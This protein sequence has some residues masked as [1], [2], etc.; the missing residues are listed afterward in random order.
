MREAASPDGGASPWLRATLVAASPD[1]L[2]GAPRASVARP[3][4][5]LRYALEGSPGAVAL[6]RV[7][8]RVALSHDDQVVVEYRALEWEY[9][10]LGP[11]PERRDDLHDFDARR[12]GWSPPSIERLLRRSG[13]GA[14]PG[15]TRLEVT[16][17]LL[18]GPGVLEGAAPLLRTPGGG[19]FGLLEEGE[20][21]ATRVSIALAGGRAP[22]APTRPVERAGRARYVA[23]RRLAARERLVWSPAT[24]SGSVE[25]WGYE[26][27]GLLD[28][29][30]DAHPRDR[31][32]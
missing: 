20:G 26:P 16:K 30:P 1:A 11:A 18:L 17:E 29:A 21:E 23:G 2:L 8:T 10:V 3:G 28:S 32:P 7:E 9:F 24:E 5:A 19:A 12:D 25:R 22:G 31:R 13:C 15:A 6:Q 4:Y 14:S 27:I